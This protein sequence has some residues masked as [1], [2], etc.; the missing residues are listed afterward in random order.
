MAI[1]ILVTLLLTSLAV[2]PGAQAATYA[3]L[4]GWEPQFM[5]ADPPPSPGPRPSVVEVVRYTVGT[6][7]ST[8]CHTAV[9]L[10]LWACDVLIGGPC[11]T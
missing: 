10:F 4:E 11:F 7:G 1:R 9:F 6:Y 3:V 2:V 5:C 8:T